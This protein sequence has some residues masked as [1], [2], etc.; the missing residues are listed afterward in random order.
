M[1]IADLRQEFMHTD[2]DENN[3]AP[4]PFSQFDRW[5]GEAAKAQMPMANA[6]TLATVSASGQPSA[7]MVLLKNVDG[8]GFVFY[9]NYKSRKGR[10]LTANPAAALLFYW[11]ELEREVRI[12][13]RVEK[14]SAQESDQYFS[15]RPLGSRHAAIASP[16][17]KAIPNRAALETRVAEREKKYGD[18]TPRPAHWGGYRL[19]PDAI[20]FWQG[21]PNRLHDRVL[22]TR[23]TRGWKITRLAP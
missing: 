12:D 17:S 4:D 1:T 13:G 15:T 6:M 10:E 20:E 18:Q 2:L 19:I 7:R 9:T 5:F 16:Q 11:P 8:G 23:H 22:Y 3:V 21:R 14:L